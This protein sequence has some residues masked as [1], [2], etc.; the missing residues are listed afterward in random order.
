MVGVMV[1]PL[2]RDL[3]AGENTGFD[4]GQKKRFS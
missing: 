3:Y 4:S 1:F 2:Q